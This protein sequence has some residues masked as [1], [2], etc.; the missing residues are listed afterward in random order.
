MIIQAL[1]IAERR[2]LGALVDVVAV[3]TV[4]GEREADATRALVRRHCVA[5]LLLTIVL[6]RCALVDVYKR[7]V[8]S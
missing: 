7:Q 3:A 8:R 5:A 1:V 6:A 4:A 2:L